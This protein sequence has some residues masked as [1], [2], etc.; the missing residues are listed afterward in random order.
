[1]GNSDTYTQWQQSCVEPR[2]FFE[3]VTYDDVHRFAKLCSQESPYPHTERAASLSV[4][5]ESV[6]LDALAG[7]MDAHPQLNIGGYG[8]SVLPE[9]ATGTTENHWTDWLPRIPEIRLSLLS[10]AGAASIEVEALCPLSHG[11]KHMIQDIPPRESSAPH[12]VSNGS[13]IAAVLM[14]PSFPIALTS[15]NP[16]LGLSRSALMHDGQT[17]SGRSP[18]TKCFVEA[19]EDRE[20]YGDF[21]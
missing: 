16:R 10:L 9:N 11:V 18:A 12:Y 17:L 2:L 6:I 15:Y 1:M 20:M 21:V 19:F 7:V 14:L 8:A 4:G 13:C 3:R 5:S